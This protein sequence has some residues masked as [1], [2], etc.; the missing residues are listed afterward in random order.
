MKEERV[1]PAEPIPGGFPVPSMPAGGPVRGA[2][3]PLTFDTPMQAPYEEA[4][5]DG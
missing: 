3:A 5:A 1:G 2:A 4:P